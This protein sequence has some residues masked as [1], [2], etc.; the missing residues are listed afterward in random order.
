MDDITYVI[1]FLERKIE[2][3]TEDSKRG[4]NTAN[5]KNFSLVLRVIND[6]RLGLDKIINADDMYCL[7]DAQY[8]AKLTLDKI[9]KECILTYEY[10]T[11]GRK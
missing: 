4:Y 2:R 11:K 3:L 10:A 8:E 9:E 1:A 5:L 7:S 6:I